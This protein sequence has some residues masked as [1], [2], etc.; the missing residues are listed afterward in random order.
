MYNRF[1][2]ILPFIAILSGLLAIVCLLLLWKILAPLGVDT[3]Q[4]IP[5]VRNTVAK[6]TA[7]HPASLDDPELLKT[8]EEAVDEP[9]I[10]TLWLIGPDGRII[11]AAGSTA[12]STP[13]GDSVKSLAT[14]DM[15]RLL[16]ALPDG[17]LNETSRLWLLA[18]SAIRREGEHNDIYRHLLRPIKLAQDGP[19]AILGVAYEASNIGPGVIYKIKILLSTF[20]SSCLIYWLSLPLCVYFDA[21]QHGE[22]ALVWAAFVLI[23]NVV[24]LIAYLLTR[25]PR[26]LRSTPTST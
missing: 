5:S 4:T 18:A 3:G 9:Y 26:L 2:K 24:A 14:S 13:V 17:I 20:M 7:L 6:I 8:L 25:T 11:W 15:Q 16:A 12:Q 1:K 10:A 23:G 21:K 22:H 19:T